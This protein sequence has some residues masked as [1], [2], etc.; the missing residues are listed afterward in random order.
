[1]KIAIESYLTEAKLREQWFMGGTDA[2]PGG[3]FELIVNHDRLSTEPVPY[4]KYLALDAYAS[5]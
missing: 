3:A 5:R 1:M 4:P 2:E